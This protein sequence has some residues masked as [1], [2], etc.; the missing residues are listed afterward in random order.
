MLAAAL[1]DASHV[2]LLFL[3][4]LVAPEPDP[5]YGLQSL[6][7]NLADFLHD[8]QRGDRLKQ[9][10]LPDIHIAGTFWKFCSSNGNSTVIENTG[11][12]TLGR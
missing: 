10:L 4:T 11:Y 12:Q 3:H 2:V 5:C 7:H 8:F 9:H 1:E 6:L